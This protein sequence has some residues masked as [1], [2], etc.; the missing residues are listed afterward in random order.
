MVLQGWDLN[1]SRVTITTPWLLSLWVVTITVE[2]AYLSHQD[3]VTLDWFRPFT[4]SQPFQCLLIGIMNGFARL[5]FEFITCYHHHT[6][7]FESMGGDNYGRRRLPFTPRWSDF[8]LIQ[9][10]HRIP[11]IPMSPYRYNEWFCKVEIW[12]HHVLPSPHHGF[13]V[14][15]WWQLR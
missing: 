3:G 11:T 8:G 15:G 13:W 5:R 1:S 9:A 14:Y 2:G 6:M 12:I 4:T 10:I 7:A